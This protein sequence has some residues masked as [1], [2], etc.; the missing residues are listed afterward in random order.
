[1]NFQDMNKVNTA[2]IINS[3]GMGHS[4]P[5]LEA[6]LVRNYFKLMVSEEYLPKFIVFYSG[7]VHLTCSGS[8]ILDNLKSLEARGVN[9]VTCKTCL[10]Y[11]GLSE[12]LEAGMLATMID[13]MD[14]QFSADKVI[15][16]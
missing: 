9:I 13:I 7:G 1:M 16:L 5:D 11:Y 10:N 14:I 15:T 3:S 12:K 8:E 4:E 6:T 2:I